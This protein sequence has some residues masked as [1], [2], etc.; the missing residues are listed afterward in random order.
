MPGLDGMDRNRRREQ[1]GR[2]ESMRLAL[3]CRRPQVLERDGRLD[4]RVL[5]LGRPAEVEGRAVP[6]RPRRERSAARSHARARPPRARASS[7]VPDGCG[8]LAPL[9]LRVEGRLQVLEREGVVEDRDVRLARPPCPAPPGRGRRAPRLRLRACRA[10]SPFASRPAHLPRLANRAVAI[11]CVDVE[12]HRLAPH[13]SGAVDLC[14]DLSTRLRLVRRL[15]RRTLV[16]D[17]PDPGCVPGVDRDDARSRLRAPASRGSSPDRCRRRR[18]AP[19]GRSPSRRIGPGSTPRPRTRNAG[20][21]GPSRR[22]LLAGVER[23]RACDRRRPPRTR[24]ARR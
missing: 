16:L 2:L 7:V 1:R 24:A 19:R 10:G 11:D 6:R 13:E 20:S 14:E 21:G 23:A 15:A 17:R 3:V 12:L 22:A 5:V 9:G 18:R 8:G 4:E